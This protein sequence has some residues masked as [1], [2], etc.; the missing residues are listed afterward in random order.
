MM[1]PLEGSR[2]DAR[3]F[4]Q[5][6]GQYPTGVTVVT[7]NCAGTPVGMVVGSFTSVSLDP[8]LI[9]FFPDKSSTTWPK[10]RPTG[11]FCVNVLSADQETVC[12]AF[13]ARAPDK[14][15]RTGWRPAASG[16]PILGGVVAWIDC[17]IW[18][19]IDAGDH[20][21]V[22]GQ[23]RDLDMPNP[24]LPLVFFRGGYGR[25]LPLSLAAGEADLVDQLRLVD[26]ARDEM[27][28]MAAELGLGWLAFCL[29][30]DELVVMATAGK[31]HN[32]TGPSRVGRRVPFAAPLGA[33][34]AAWATEPE[35]RAWVGRLGVP[36]ADNSRHL[37]ILETIRRRGYSITGGRET[38]RELESLMSRLTAEPHLVGWTEKLRQLTAELS[39]SSDPDELDAYSEYEVR[40]IHAPVFGPDRRVAYSIDLFLPPNVTH[41]ERILTY[42]SRLLHAADRA[43]RAAGGS[44][45][46]G[47]PPS[48]D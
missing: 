31:G 47:W 46:A 18:S 30:R 36:D 21:I 4:R 14:F 37:K 28:A 40:A 42:A 6:L 16:S 24:A 35:V 45:P 20:F 10:I 29:V 44:P 8:M 34:F 15:D 11:S 38:H 48:V 17:D 9:A 19:V 33:V 43:T 3:W 5:V 1:Q 7:A 27:E 25:F 23:V 13:T 32:M 39:H 22:I 12:R 41:R 2:P 26:L